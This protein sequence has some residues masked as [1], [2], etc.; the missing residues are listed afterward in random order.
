MSKSSAIWTKYR[1][2]MRGIPKIPLII[3]LLLFSAA[4]FAGHLTAHDPEV[5]EPRERLKPPAWMEGGTTKYLLGSD[6]MGRDVLTRLIYGSRVSL[7]VAFT[8]VI[9]SGFI[10]T[11]IG[12][13]SGFFGGWVDQIIMRFTDAWLCIPAVMIAILL[14]VV[15]GPSISNIVLIMTIIYWTRYARLTRGETLSLKS[16]DFVHLA[17]IAGCGKFK[18]MRRHILPNVMNTVITLASLQIGIVIVVEASLT[19]LGVGV[20]PPKP[21][22]G[23]MLSEGRSGLLTG[24]WWLI[25]FPGI[26]IAMLVMSFNLIGDW[27]R[28]RLDPH[29]QEMQK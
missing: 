21:A 29:V 23:L 7:V 13:F 3:L 14:A 24:H 12:V 25:I 4:I 1:R 8:A 15:L 11:A 27:L 26:A 28:V 20:P 22:W 17:T 9:L 5:G 16:R 18:I 10:G 6:T 2:A 19:F